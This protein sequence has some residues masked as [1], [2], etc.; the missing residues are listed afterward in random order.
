MRNVSAICALGFC[1]VLFA[2]GCSGDGDSNGS[3]DITA[4]QAG[5]GLTGGGD[6]GD[7]TLEADT[8][9]LQRRVSAGCT[10]EKAIQ[11]ISSIGGVV[12]SENFALETHAHSEY[13]AVDHNHDADYSAID[14]N[15]DADY[16]AI[17]HDHDADY[18]AIDHNHDAA[19]SAIDH[20]HDAAYLGRN[21]TETT[22]AEE[23]SGLVLGTP[24]AVLRVI[25]TSDQSACGAV[26][27]DK[28]GL[29]GA[30]TGD[31]AHKY[32]VVGY[33]SGAGMRNIGVLGTTTNEADVNI[34]GY[35]AGDTVITGHLKLSHTSP[36]FTGVTGLASN[37]V[38][39]YF[40]VGN[41]H[42]ATIAGDLPC[43][44]ICA[45]HGM[46]CGLAIRTDGVLSNCNFTAGDVNSFEY[47]WCRKP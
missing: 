25:N 8:E 5:T 45:R 11:S 9:Y 30:S 6:T 14:H 27:C 21:V 7:V 39:G 43:D 24:P 13:A 41:F 38:G 46:E 3:G 20:N 37:E 26:N 33:A 16:S 22:T 17:G 10:G 12:C 36:G 28:N 31:N 47:C 4:V 35:F 42:N 32:G 23:A 1:C 44:T 18:S 34:A 19:Y 40:V 15:H 29:V 2:V